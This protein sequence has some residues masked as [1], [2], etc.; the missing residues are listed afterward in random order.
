[1]LKKIDNC[2]GVYEVYERVGILKVHREGLSHSEIDD[3]NAMFV[4]STFKL[5]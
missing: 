2:D 1:M 4:G 5:V 3:F